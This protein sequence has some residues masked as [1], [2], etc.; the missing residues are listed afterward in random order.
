MKETRSHEF[1]LLIDFWLFL[2]QSL[3]AL[4]IFE[5]ILQKCSLTDYSISLLVLITSTALSSLSFFSESLANKGDKERRDK[6]VHTVL[7]YSSFFCAIVLLIES[8]FLFFVNHRRSLLCKVFSHV[9]CV[10]CSYYC[11]VAPTP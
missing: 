4:K 2:G 11:A 1:S 9:R 5:Q 6:K 7:K 8:G 10:F 3:S